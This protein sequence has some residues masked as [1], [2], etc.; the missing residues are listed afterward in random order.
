MR[1]AFIA[2]Q[3]DNYPVR[4]LCKVMQVQASG[5]Y[6]WLKR[7][8]SERLLKNTRL[9]GEI[10]RIH[11]ENRCVYG[12]PR[13]HDELVGLGFK[14]SEGRV[15]RLMRAHGIASVHK[16]KYKA[17]TNSAHGF[18]VAEN[19]LQQNF[20]ANA[21][22]RVWVADI[23][24]IAT[25]EGWLYLAAVVDLYSRAVVGW[26]L[27][28]QMTRKLVMDALKMAYWKRKPAPGLIHHSDRGSQY[29]SDDFQKLLTAYGMKCSMS[30]KGCCWD[31]AVAESF[32][33]TLKVELVHR[34]NYR[35]REQAKS[36]IFEYIEVFYNRKRRHSYLQGVTPLQFEMRLVA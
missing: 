5:F 4:I 29:A 20:S 19:L 7:S 30:A 24:Y 34:T 23:T 17:T 18:P 36:E 12:R 31:N 1:F 32:F 16:R 33:H 15:G 6:A 25:D 22:N 35:T 13:I 26:S 9:V 21:Q 28:R 10:K 27:D 14:C 8:P 2:A 11:E 3:Q